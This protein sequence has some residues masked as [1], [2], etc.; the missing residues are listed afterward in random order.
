MKIIYNILIISS[1]SLISLFISSCTKEKINVENQKSF[2][3]D[4]IDDSKDVIK[5]QQYLFFKKYNSHL[6][7]NPEIKDY[8]FNFESPNKL[9]IGRLNQEKESLNAD[10]QLLNELFLDLY[11]DEF[12]KKNLPYSIILTKSIVATVGSGYSA[13]KVPY[14]VYADPRFMAIS[15]FPE[16]GSKLSDADK[17]ALKG[18]INSKFWGY[19]LSTIKNSFKVNAEFYTVTNPDYY[20]QKTSLDPNTFNWYDLGFVSYDK[21][22]SSYDDWFE[23][24]ETYTPTKE[25]DLEQWIEFVFTKTKAE[26]DEIFSSSPLMQQKYDILKQSFEQVG[27]DISS[28]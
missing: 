11:S 25:L 1:L 19:Y 22:K 17:T 5:H 28:L 20:G 16:N 8:G 23:E 7:L 18:A 3:S 26:R 27:F 4:D 6:I 2:Y 12:K 9:E 15:N 14:L 10:I 24:Y 13:K 21:V